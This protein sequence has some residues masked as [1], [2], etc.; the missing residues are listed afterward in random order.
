MGA[1]PEKMNP[2]N[3]KNITLGVTGSV[4][5]YK[6]VDLASKLHQAGARVTCILTESAAKFVSP[7]SFESI[8]GLKAYRDADLWGA[9][10]HIV[11]VGLGQT[12]D[13]ILIAPVSANTIGKLANG[14]ADNLLTVTALAARCPVV[15]A[16]AMDLG[17]YNHPAN[18][19]NVE[20]LKARGVQFIGP[21]EGHLASGL[22]GLGRF[23]E[24]PEI[25]AIVRK[26][27]ASDGALK[28]KRVLVTA[29]GTQEAIDPVRVITNHS[30]GKQGFAIA[31]AALDLGAE[32]TV[33]Q[34]NTSVRA[35]AGVRLIR[36]ASAAEM[37]K[38]VLAELSEANALVM[39][40]AVADFRPADPKKQK[41]KKEAGLESI[42]LEPTE[43]ILKSVAAARKKYKNLQVV[44]GF[45]AESQNLAAN[46]RKKLEAKKL[47][48]IVANDISSSDAGFAVDTNRA[49][50][51]L[52]DGTQKKLEL[53][54]K[55]EI[56]EQ[57]MAIVTDL[58]AVK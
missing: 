24:P 48:L 9:E 58:V 20:V 27:L 30:S 39:A 13:L 35:P 12:S 29:G 37:G 33:I 14:I 53:A 41:I 43:D 42:Q 46:A 8:T 19:H 57:V 15:L 4:A 45:A 25:V 26:M 21:A 28:G 17:M 44:V 55:T 3:G 56:A 38:A 40:A 1:E 51:F 36:V 47:E 50:V 5:A 6:A 18:Q 2:L 16:P 10:G 23:V 54:S 7:L 32:V 34:G 22:T 49:T 31:Q 11:H 52:A